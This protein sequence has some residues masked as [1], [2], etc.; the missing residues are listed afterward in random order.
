MPNVDKAEATT[1]A[2]GNG[3]GRSALWLQLLSVILFVALWEGA[4]I[5]ADTHTLPTPMAVLK[6]LF[7]GIAS[8]ELPY[9]L[10]V[11][12]L[13]VGAS[14]IIA[15]LLGTVLGIL[16][17]RVRLADRLLDSWLILFLNLPALVTT[18]LVYVWF[19]LIEA[20]AILAVTINK[21]P[22]VI[23][24]VREGARALDPDL[25]E[26]GKSFRLGSMRMLLHVVLP[27]LYPYLIAAARS[28]LSLVWKIVLVV[29]L[30]GRSNGVGFQ[31]Q[32]F[33]QLFDVTSILAY[34][35][36]FIAVIQLIEHGLLQPLER[37]ANEWR[38]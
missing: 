33:F 28:G 25:L 24:M 1:A 4:A 13:R 30:L 12:M 31:L 8:G 17:G 26:M 2:A 16:M 9:H 11:T 20:A 34:T 15:L 32:M 10:G 38:R 6:A 21:V 37:R 36:A 5:I 19:G 14:F 18:I 35:L 29:E 23:V 3:R 27:Q 7:T 22:T